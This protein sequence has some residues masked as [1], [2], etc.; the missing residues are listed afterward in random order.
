M[1]DMFSLEDKVAIVTGGNGGIGYGISKGFARA[2]ANI[3]I[4]ARNVHKTAKAAEIIQSQY[5]VKV[6][7]VE[8]DVKQEGQI[9]RMVEETVERFGR[10]DILVNNAGINIRKMPQ[11][12]SSTEYDVILDVN[13]RGAFLCSKAVYPIMQEM[14][15][16]KIINIGSMTSIFG[17]AKLVAYGTSKGGIVAM[18]R[19]LAVA[20]AQDNIQVNTILPGWI[21]TD[22]TKRAQKEIEGLNGRVLTRTP[23]GRWGVSEDMQ[24][25][26][27]YLASK[28]SDFVTGVALPVDGGYSIKI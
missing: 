15:G 26:A 17:G 27:I 22:L 2:G 19:A 25:T 5:G 9:N 16:G 14:G 7:E 1:M 8:V 4:A 11:N 28:A 6:L 12:L 24:G 18:T 23:V 13:L 10:I 21:D 20:W 3:V